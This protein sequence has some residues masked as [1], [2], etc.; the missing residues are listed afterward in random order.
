MTGDW[1]HEQWKVPLR[2]TAKICC[3]VEKRALKDVM[4]CVTLIVFDFIGNSFIE[5]EFIPRAC[6]SLT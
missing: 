6:N 5:I 2:N 1:F 3:S 4:K